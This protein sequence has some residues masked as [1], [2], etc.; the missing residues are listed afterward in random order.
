MTLLIIS[1]WYNNA[2]R[3]IREPRLGH[4]DGWSPF[5]HFSTTVWLEINQPN[6]TRLRII[7]HTQS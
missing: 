1:Y 2:Q 6:F 7:S 4:D 5:I 3:K